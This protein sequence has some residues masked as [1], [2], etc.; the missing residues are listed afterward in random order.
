MARPTFEQAKRLYINRYT[1]EHVPAWA[2]KICINGLFYAPQFRSDAEWFA[3]TK[4]NGD[5]GWY[6]I[7]SDCQTSGQTWPMGEWLESPYYTGVAA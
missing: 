6:G 4:F 2:R 5:A 7:G 1:M 3:N